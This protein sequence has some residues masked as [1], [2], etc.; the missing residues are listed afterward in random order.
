MWNCLFILLIKWSLFISIDAGPSPSEEWTRTVIEAASS[1]ST[2]KTSWNKNI[3]DR[4]KLGYSRIIDSMGQ[5]K[6][7]HIFRHLPFSSRTNTYNNTDTNSLYR[8]QKKFNMLSSSSLTKEMLQGDINS[9]VYL[10]KKLNIS[11]KNPKGN[12]L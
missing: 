9:A 7:R 8:S 4:L 6:T 1:L 11:K 3:K 5:L 12:R 10:A 2:G